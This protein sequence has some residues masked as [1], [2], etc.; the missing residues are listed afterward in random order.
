MSVESLIGYL[1]AI[2]PLSPPF[3][4]EM[5]AGLQTENYKARQI[6]HAAGQTENRLWYLESG[7]ARTYYFDQAG[8]E[9]TLIF[10]EEKELIFSYKGFWKE[11]TDYYLEVLKPSSLI[12]LSYEYLTGLFQLEET[13]ILAQ[14]FIRQRHQD[15]LFKSRMMTWT[16]EERYKQFRKIHPEIFGKTSVRLIASYLNMTRENLSRL[17]SRDNG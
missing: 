16:A 13:K 8:K 10:Y 4:E 5:Q 1:S 3:K 17:I 12:S 15:D 6:I 11:S 14:V 9:H 7:F 2:T